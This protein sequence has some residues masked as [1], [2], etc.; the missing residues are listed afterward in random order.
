MK[1]T[2]TIKNNETGETIFNDETNA[3]IAGIGATSV[4]LTECNGEEVLKTA[5]SAR[6]AIKRAIPKNSPL[7]ALLNL[8]DT[9]DDTD[10]EPV[11]EDN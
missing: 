8:V 7:L 5:L 11:K 6:K 3:F 9:L 2:V 10:D 4:L 1:F